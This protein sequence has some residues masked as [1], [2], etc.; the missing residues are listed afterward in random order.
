MQA[1]REMEIGVMFWAGRDPVETLREVKSLGV[2]C[3]QLGVPGSL[4]LDE[5]TTAAWKQALESERFTLVTV[6]A[7]YEGE[8]YADI[9]TVQKTVGFIPPATREQR[10]ARTYAVSDF[11][12][13][14]G[15]PSIACHVG[16]VP[17]D[18]ESPDYKAVREM[19][20]RVADYAARHH[21]T[22]DAPV[23][24]QLRS[25]QHSLVGVGGSHLVALLGKDVSRVS[26]GQLLGWSRPVGPASSTALVL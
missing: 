6:F 23:V 24:H 22:P 12:A 26:H 15:A 20:R 21:Q 3:G 9:P 4:P 18:P 2:R 25:I 5:A 13:A 8:S 10:E 14:L 1:L 16:F 7:A 19:V 17:E 11:A